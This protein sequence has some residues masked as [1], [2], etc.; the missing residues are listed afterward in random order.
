MYPL[1]VDLLSLLLLPSS[2][3]TLFPVIEHFLVFIHTQ[4]LYCVSQRTSQNDDFFLC[5]WIQ[6]GL[7]I[8]KMD[9]V[10][11]NTRHRVKLHFSLYFSPSLASEKQLRMM[12]SPWASR[13]RSLKSFKRVAVSLAWRYKSAENWLF[14]LITLLLWHC[15]EKMHTDR[16][17]GHGETVGS[18]WRSL[19]C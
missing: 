10:W 9:T 6:V 18:H 3:K 4:F 19:L 5:R 15:R 11:S 12:V 13:K 16:E 2:R 1:L 8:Y 14:C 7:V 17:I